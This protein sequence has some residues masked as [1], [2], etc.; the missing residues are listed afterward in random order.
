MEMESNWPWGGICQTE[1]RLEMT[2]YGHTDAQNQGSTS[3]VVGKIT[4]P[5]K[6][7][8]AVFAGDMVAC[9]LARGGFHPEADQG[10]P[11]I[12][13]T[14][15][16]AIT[17]VYEPY[18]A[19]D[20]SVQ[21]AGGAAAL[22]L[23]KAQNGIKDMPYADLYPKAGRNTLSA[24]QNVAAALKFG[25][26]GIALSV[27]QSLQGEAGVNLNSDIGTIATQVGLFATDAAADNNTTVNRAIHDLLLKNADPGDTLRTAAVVRFGGP[28]LLFDT[29]KD[30]PTDANL[31]RHLQAHA[32]QFLFG[33]ITAAQEHNR[34]GVKGM[35]CGNANPG[36]D[37]AILFG[38]H[39]K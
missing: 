15:P 38:F 1:Q 17:A 34:A 35:A 8:K 10:F 26:M 28:D 19:T 21:M 18:V 27:I 7:T 31:M 6:S 13:G 36:E 24:E 30:Q 37:V 33:G 25:I 23:T 2:E 11:Y 32:L 20:L 4:I 12:V 3:F 14:I 5:W 9:R 39:C 29:L 22:K 16:R